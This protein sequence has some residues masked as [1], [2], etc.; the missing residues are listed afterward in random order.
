VAQIASLSPNRTLVARDLAA[1]VR[2]DVLA[3]GSVRIELVANPQ[4]T[5]GDPTQDTPTPLSCL[6]T[7]TPGGSDD[8]S[9]TATGPMTVPP[10]SVIFMRITVSSA[11]PGVDIAPE[12]ASWGI[13]VEPG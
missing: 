13:T 9:C 8:R 4:S 1:R 11:L 12:R 2:N 6:I 3:G 10:A 7:S 5:S